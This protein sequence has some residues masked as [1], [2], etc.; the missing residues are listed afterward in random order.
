MSHLWFWV[1]WLTTP[2]RSNIYKSVATCSGPEQT[3]HLRTVLPGYSSHGCKQDNVTSY[4]VA[5]CSW[6]NVLYSIVCIWL[7]Y[8]TGCW[9]KTCFK[10]HV[11]SK[12]TLILFQNNYC[13]TAST[14]DHSLPHQPPTVCENLPP[15]LLQ[16]VPQHRRP[17]GLRAEPPPVYSVH[18]RLHPHPPLKRHRKVSGWYS[19]GGIHTQGWWVS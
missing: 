11:G 3:F 16:P 2:R 5:C 8:K 7:W 13:A 6:Y 12:I 4:V 10:V 9:V 17:T 18:A 1:Y 14:C 19:R 15:L